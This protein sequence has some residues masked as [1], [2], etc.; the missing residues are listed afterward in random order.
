M[1]PDSVPE[2]ASAKAWKFLSSSESN[3][4]Q[5]IMNLISTNDHSVDHD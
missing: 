5:N 1:K 3:V 4:N 2:D